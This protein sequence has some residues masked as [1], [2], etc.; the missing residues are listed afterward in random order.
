MENR[1]QMQTKK[2]IRT[3]RNYRKTAYHHFGNTPTSIVKF[4]YYS[5]FKR[6]LFIVF[7]ISLDKAIPDCPLDPDFTVIKPTLEE[8][9]K[10]R[11]GKEL[12]REF[13]YDEFHGVRRCYVAL[14]DGDL[15]YIHWVYVKGDYNRFLRLSEGVAELNYNTFLP[16]YRGKGLAAK[17]QV[18]ILKDL[19]KEGFRMVVGVV[20]SENPP[21]LKTA[22]KV[23][24][25]EIG[26]IRTIGPFSRRFHI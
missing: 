26:R 10:L 13:S 1:W 15:A 23:G 8:L 12:P 22:L 9:R 3:L 19:Q 16:K 11:E 20:H 5:L 24:F 21:A 7:G 25:Q 17:M 2:L 6:N 4:S 14:C 18:Y